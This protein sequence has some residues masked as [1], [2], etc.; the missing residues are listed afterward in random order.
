ME[1]FTGTCY[2]SFYVG[3]ALFEVVPGMWRRLP[4]S[5]G[6]LQILQ[7]QVSGRQEF[8]PELA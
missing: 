6:E 1:V 4:A 3:A 2:F 7:L 8:F 5:G